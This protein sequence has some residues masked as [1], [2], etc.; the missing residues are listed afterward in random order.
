MMIIITIIR[1]NN[2]NYYYYLYMDNYNNNN[3]YNIGITPSIIQLHN[4][5]L[6]KHISY[7][8]LL[9][10]HIIIYDMYVEI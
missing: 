4:L 10:K 9:Q 7:H 1:D 2:N 5:T 8:S 6:Q 3:Y